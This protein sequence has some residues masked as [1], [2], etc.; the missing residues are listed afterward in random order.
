MEKKTTFELFQATEDIRKNDLV[1]TDN[2]GEAR[3]ATTPEV[4]EHYDY[5]QLIGELVD[6]CDLSYID[7]VIEIIRDT[8]RHNQEKAF[9]AMRIQESHSSK[10]CTAEKCSCKF[11]YYN[12]KVKEQRIRE[13][14]FKKKSNL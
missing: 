10:K 3:K 4:N 5:Q 13:E 12:A 1:V 9:R 2:N 14:E 6:Y 11:K 8:V 7:N